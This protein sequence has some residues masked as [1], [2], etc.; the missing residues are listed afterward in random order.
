MNAPADILRFW[1]GARAPGA[2]VDAERFALW[3]MKSPETDGVIRARFEAD[4][5]AA[6]AGERDAWGGSAEGALAL[7][8]LLDQ[9]PR[10]IYRDA[11]RAFA[12]DSQAL[13]LSLDGQ[14]RGLDLALDVPERGFFYLPMEHAESAEMQERS[15][16]AFAR[17]AASAPPEHAALAANFHDYAIRHRDVIARF[18]RYPHRNA[19]LG[20]PSTPEEIEFLKQPGSSF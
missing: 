14:A 9:F 19:I 6:A 12:F 7:I 2:P 1:F 8:V 16:A 17:L 15:V 13:A 11:P 5:L 18:G 4:V 20:R 10:N 3:F